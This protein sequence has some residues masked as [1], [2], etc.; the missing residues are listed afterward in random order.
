LST[1]TRLDHGDAELEL[2]LEAARRASWDALHGPI[3]L[4]SGR[5]RPQREASEE[6][7]VSEYR[8]AA[9]DLNSEEVD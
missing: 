8:G 1:N 6:G 9:S 7:A 2:L 5:F 3:Y 4:R